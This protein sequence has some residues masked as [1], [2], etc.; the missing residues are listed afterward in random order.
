MTTL[1]AELPDQGALTGLVQRITGLGLKVVDPAPPHAA[2]AM[3]G[4]VHLTVQNPPAARPSQD[5]DATA[6]G[7]AFWEATAAHAIRRICRGCRGD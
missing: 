5:L 1:R 4:L 2:W 6:A 7:P 3:T